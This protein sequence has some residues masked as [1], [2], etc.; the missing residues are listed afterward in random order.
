MIHKPVLPV[1]RTSALQVNTKLAL[2]A[3]VPK[4]T[5]HKFVHP[6]VMEELSIPV[7]VEGILQALFVMERVLLI[8]RLVHFVLLVLLERMPI[9]PI[10]AMEMV[11]R[12]PKLV[13]LVMQ[14]VPV[15]LLEARIWK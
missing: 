3:M 4:P 9:L 7:G 15:V 10:N 14:L 6:V 8:L 13:V 11:T 1:G 2:S 12:I 5:I